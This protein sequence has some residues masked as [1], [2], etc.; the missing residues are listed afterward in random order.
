MR[1]S[2]GFC[3]ALGAILGAIL[4]AGALIWTW[5]GNARRWYGPK[6]WRP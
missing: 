1:D 2:Y 4:M 5:A 3:I 6:R